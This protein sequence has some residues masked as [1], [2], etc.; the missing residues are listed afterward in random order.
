[1]GEEMGTLNLVLGI[2]VGGVD[3]IQR[4]S[5]RR[6][7][8]AFSTYLDFFLEVR[9]AIKKHS[10]G[11]NRVLPLPEEENVDSN[12][13]DSSRVST[14]LPKANIAGKCS[15][16]RLKLRLK[17]RLPYGFFKFMNHRVSAEAREKTPHVA[18]SLFQIPVE[19]E[20][21]SPEVGPSMFDFSGVSGWP[22]PSSSSNSSS[23]WIV[24]SGATHHVCFFAASFERG[25]PIFNSAVFLPNGD[26]VPVLGTGSV[27]L[28]ND[29]TLQ[30]VLFIPQ[31][32]CN[33]LSISALT[34]QHRYVVS[35]HHD[36]YVI[37]DPTQGRRIGMGRQVGNLYILDLSNMFF[38]S[39]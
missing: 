33:L 30:N 5:G 9:E 12:S 35:F 1:M 32:H 24:D 4:F 10:H 16:I 31:F 28:C 8:K 23:L 38:V 11:A 36:H 19:E 18:N 39:L 29:L 27:R 21:A 25:D 34:Q 7:K 3:D 2:L 6:L 13:N 17:L 26:R 20:M 37:E 14:S 22:L 15:K